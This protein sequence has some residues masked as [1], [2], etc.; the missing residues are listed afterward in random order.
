MS[1]FTQPFL[2]TLPSIL[3][4]QASNTNSLHQTTSKVTS[5]FPT[6]LD[7]ASVF[8]FND[9]VTNLK[10]GLSEIKQVDQYAQAI[11]SIP[12]ISTYEAVASLSEFELMDILMDNMEEHK[13][14]LRAYYKRELYDALVKSY[15]TDKDLFYTYGEV[16]MLKRSQDDKDKDQDPSTRSDQGTKRRKSSKDVESSRDLKSKESKSTSSSKELKLCQ[17]NND[18]QPNDEAASKV[19]QFKKPEQP[20]TPDPDWNKRQH[21]DFRPPQTWI[22]NIARAENPPTSLDEL[23]DTPIDFFMFVMNRINII[24]LTQELLVGPAFNLLKGTCKSRTELEYHFEEY[25]KATTKRLNW[26]NLKVTSLKIKKRYDYDH[27]DEIEV[28]REDQQLYKFK[29]G[30]FPR[31][32]LQDIEDMLLLLVQQKLTNLTIDKRFDLNVELQIWMEYLPKRNWSGLDKRRACF[33]IQDIDKRL[34]QRRLMQNLEKFVGGREYGEDLR[35]L[36]RTI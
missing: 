2:T 28:R 17:G 4:L 11:S 31:L 34:L 18:E 35:L 36:E 27:L 15:N 32:R 24:N 6:L 21:V 7:F 23:M 10:R 20:L 16:F 14:Y 30:D 29:E 25:F 19:D 26:H 22:T 33:M 9:R 12:A 3:L 8:R 13:S 1:A 5:H